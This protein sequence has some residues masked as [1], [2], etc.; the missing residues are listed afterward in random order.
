MELGFGDIIALQNFIK[1]STLAHQW[2][3]L[4]LTSAYLQSLVRREEDQP[5]LETLGF[6]SFTVIDKSMKHLKFTISPLSLHKS[7]SDM[8]LRRVNFSATRR[9]MTSPTW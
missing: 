8:P 3:L 2:P 5:D 6:S 4:H 7:R 1:H 9:R